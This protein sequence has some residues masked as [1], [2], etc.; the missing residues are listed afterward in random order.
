MTEM[1]GVTNCGRGCREHGPG[2][3][4]KR[5]ERVYVTCYGFATKAGIVC[6]RIQ[7]ITCTIGAQTTLCSP[8]S[9]F[10]HR[11]ANAET[12]AGWGDDDQETTTAVRP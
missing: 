12:T 6:G 3:L 7:D 11:T 2:L 8:S 10:G 9:H 5:A 4:E 1:T